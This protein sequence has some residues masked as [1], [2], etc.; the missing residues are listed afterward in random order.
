MAS[1]VELAYMVT[2]DAMTVPSDSRKVESTGSSLHRVQM[3]MKN[4]MKDW[5]DPSTGCL[6]SCRMFHLIAVTA[7]D[8]ERSAAWSSKSAIAE[9]MVMLR[10]VQ[11]LL[12]SV[13]RL[14]EQTPILEFV[15]ECLRM[16]ASEAKQPRNDNRDSSKTVLA[17]NLGTGNTTYK[18]TGARRAPAMC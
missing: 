1:L 11:L 2:P 8:A 6:A 10:S 17:M 18:R 7:F 3:R 9:A 5:G 14:L 12:K 4:S 15:K 13:G 16:F